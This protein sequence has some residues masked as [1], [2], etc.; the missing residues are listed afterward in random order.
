LQLVHPVL[1]FGHTHFQVDQPRSDVGDKVSA[2]SLVTDPQGLTKDGP[3][4]R[5][6]TPEK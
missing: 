4:Q 2:V 1:A 5:T 6:A 3:R